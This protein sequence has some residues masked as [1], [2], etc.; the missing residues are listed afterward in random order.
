MVRLKLNLQVCTTSST[1]FLLITRLQMI[2]DQVNCKTC[3]FSI[4]LSVVIT[5]STFCSLVFSVYFLQEPELLRVDAERIQRQMQ[6]VA[7]GNYRS[8][9]AAA[10]ALLAVQEEVTSIDKHLESIVS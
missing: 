1:H 7:V 9:I 6:E 2:K 4:R 5:N 8:F 3:A 10:D